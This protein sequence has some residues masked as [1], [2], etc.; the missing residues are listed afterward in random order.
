MVRRLVMAAIAAFG[1]L[2]LAES[3]S[4]VIVTSP[5]ELWTVVGNRYVGVCD[6]VCSGHGDEVWCVGD[7]QEQQK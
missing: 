7:R 2:L 1:L 3:I 6:R 4:A 5:S